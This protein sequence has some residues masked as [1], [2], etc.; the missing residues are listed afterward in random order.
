MSSNQRIRKLPL[1]SWR[2]RRVPRG[3]GWVDHRLLKEKLVCQCSSDALALYLILVLAADGEGLSFYG[4]YS[5]CSLLGMDM[6][7]LE[8]ARENLI[9]NDLIAW[10]KPLYQV[11]EVLT[12]QQKEKFYGTAHIN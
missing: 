8:L 11:L 10:E 2:L 9:Y 3:F 6:Q 12:A 7:R 1:K 5:L 4:D